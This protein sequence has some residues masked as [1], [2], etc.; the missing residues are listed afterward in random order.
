MLAIAQIVVSIIL[1]ALILLQER[2]SGLSG[3]LGGGGEGSFYQTRRGLE[4]FVFWATIASAVV[5]ALL[6]LADLLL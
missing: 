5:F 1:I 2:T 4:K 3:I 6:A